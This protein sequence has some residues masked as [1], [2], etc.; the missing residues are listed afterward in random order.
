MSQTK[1]SSFFIREYFI[2]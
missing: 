2:I 1:N